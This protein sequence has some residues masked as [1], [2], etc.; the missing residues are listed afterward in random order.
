MSLD[1]APMP[2]G[3]MKVDMKFSGEMSCG[4]G[5]TRDPG[6]LATAEAPEFTTLPDAA[7][8]VA[9]RALSQAPHLAALRISCDLDTALWVGVREW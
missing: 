4:M 2:R 7:S 6:R 3:A 8:E 1:V 9:K 5:S